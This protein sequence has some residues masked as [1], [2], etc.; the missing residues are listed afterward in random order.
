MPRF[1]GQ[2]FTETEDRE[3][4]LACIHAYNDW[5]VEEWCGD[6]GGRLIPLI[7]VPLWDAGLAATECTAT[8]SAACAR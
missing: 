4:G 5:M 7:I 1:C 8:P 3:L 2:V 6:S